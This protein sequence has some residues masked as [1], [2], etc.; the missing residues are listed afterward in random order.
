MWEGQGIRTAVSLAV[1]G[2]IL[3]HEVAK[4]LGARHIFVERKDGK[5]GLHRGFTLKRGEKVLIVEDVITTGGS[6]FEAVESVESQGAEI[7]G[8][9]AILKR[10]DAD[11]GY[12]L[13]V[14][15]EADWKKFTPSDCPL[16]REGMPLTAPGTK[17]S[18]RSRN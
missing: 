6:V 15:L 7:T 10:G 13:R 18:S 2:I 5:L 16:C 17:Q 3:G 14:L 1:G 12:P 11:F 4:A 9:A 8:I